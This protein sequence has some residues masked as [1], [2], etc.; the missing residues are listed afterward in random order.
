MAYLKD[1]ERCGVLEC[2]HLLRDGVAI[3]LTSH[4]LGHGLLPVTALL[5]RR[6]QLL[7]AREDAVE[8]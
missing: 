8:R 3:V 7:G 4:G 5:Q 1:D 2:G 6:I